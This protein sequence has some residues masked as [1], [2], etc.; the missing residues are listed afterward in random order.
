[1]KSRETHET[2]TLIGFFFAYFTVTGGMVAASMPALQNYWS[3]VWPIILVA[4]LIGGASILAS[5]F[6]G[7]RT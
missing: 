3:T 6:V 4:G 1:M 5:R 2:L 7:S